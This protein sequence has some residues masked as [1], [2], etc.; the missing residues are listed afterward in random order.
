MNGKKPWTPWTIY[1]S[2][3]IQ[4]CIFL[5]FITTS[6]KM[7]RIRYSSPLGM[8]LLM[9]LGFFVGLMTVYFVFSFIHTQPQEPGLLP[10]ELHGMV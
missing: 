8:I 2:F 1:Q 10:S 7:F 9:I 3:G 4:R 5:C 6:E